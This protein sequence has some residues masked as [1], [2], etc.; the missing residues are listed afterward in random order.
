MSQAPV[1][2]WGVVGND[3]LTLCNK[4]MGIQG[5]SVL[6]GRERRRLLVSPVLGTPK[7]SHSDAFCQV[8]F[9]IPNFELRTSMLACLYGN[10]GRFW[11]EIAWALQ[12]SYRGDISQCCTLQLL[13]GT[14][15][16]HLG[17]FCPSSHFFASPMKA[18]QSCVF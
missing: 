15:A 3:P 10:F 14:K 16:S 17:M 6:V 11:Q 8:L 2:V 5:H 7:P 1:V 13:S 9:F 4:I 18:S 12:S